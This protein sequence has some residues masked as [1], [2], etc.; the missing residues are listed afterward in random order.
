MIR[1]AAQSPAR[2]G[3]MSPIPA[4]PAGPAAAAL[5]LSPTLSDGAGEEKTRAAWSGSGSDRSLNRTTNP[6]RGASCETRR[7]SGSDSAKSSRAGED[8]AAGGHAAQ[9]GS[10]P[11]RQLKGP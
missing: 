2:S 3:P 7:P 8:A 11:E 5:A 1:P 6:A 4:L 9:T 10:S